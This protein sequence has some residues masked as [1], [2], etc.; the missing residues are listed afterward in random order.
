MTST[1]KNR[2]VI[3]FVAQIA[4]AA[5]SA[6]VGD[7][8]MFF[9]GTVACSAFY[10]STLV[11]SKSLISHLAPLL[12]G[13]AVFAVTG[14]W[15]YAIVF[16]FYALV[17]TVLSVCVKKEYSRS[18]SVFCLAIT[19]AS[20]IAVCYVFFFA[21][22]ADSFSVTELGNSLKTGINS[23]IDKT[24]STFIENFK[25]Q[26]DA[27][28]FKFDIVEFTKSFSS[29]LYSMS[30]G[31][32]AF[33]INF[34][35]YISTWIF[36]LTQKGIESDKIKRVFGKNEWSFVLSKVSAVV[37]IVTLLLIAIGGD[38]L[39]RPQNVAF[40]AVFIA[41]SG[42]VFIMAF[43]K[44]RNSVRN[45]GSYLF[46]VMLVILAIFFDM[47]I[48]WLIIFGIG[49]YAALSYKDKKEDVNE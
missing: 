13:L 40:Y 12:S 33:V 27:S 8:T 29:M 31:I 17:G 39:T 11:I 37:F 6:F 34:A 14:M 18:K 20:S 30:F 15:G 3:L 47:Y 1:V 48:A 43:N 42:G 9:F 28:G 19:I 46:P 22:T 21:M 2:Y 25:L 49:L 41:I 45:T 23:F 7:L 5:F 26:A 4:I 38:T 24:V 32:V 10:A 35:S 36:K 44:L 16:A